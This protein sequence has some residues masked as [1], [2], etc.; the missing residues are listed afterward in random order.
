MIVSQHAS[1][2]LVTIDL[3][4]TLADVIVRL[5]DFVADALVVSFLMIMEQIFAGSIAKH[6]LAEKYQP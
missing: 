5:D 4:F 1:E 3:A 2:P 6:V